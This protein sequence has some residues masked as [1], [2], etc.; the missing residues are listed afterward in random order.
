MSSIPSC[1]YVDIHSHI[2]YG[3]DDGAQTLEQS[4]AMLEMAASGGTSDIVATP[5]SDLTY[6]F[7]QD[8]AAERIAELNSAL[9]RRIH[10]HCGC[11][12][13]LHFDNIQDCL[14]NPARYTINHGPYLLVEF[15]N[16]QIARNIDDVFRRMLVLDIRPIIT[17]PERN[18]LLRQRMDE[19][20]NWVRAGCLVQV[21][22][23][24]FLDRFGATARQAADELMERRMVH[25]VAS[26]AHDTEH[27][28]PLLGNA[29]EYVADRY[30][31]AQARALFAEHPRA[32]LTGRY[33]DVEDPAPAKRKRWFWF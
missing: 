12:F 3:L 32:T 11:D 19:M 22:A 1:S 4:V 24:S 29:F 7:Q 8:L 25:F 28:P 16:R 33:L 15:D 26:D 20:A 6:R 17:H 14:E 23:Q 18:P 31:E 9:G 2:L 5:H 21:T 30:G 27:R 13:H 10:I